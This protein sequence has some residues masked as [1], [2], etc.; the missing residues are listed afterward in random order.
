[1]RAVHL[2]GAN[3]RST[4]PP[5]AKRA[6][7]SND[8]YEIFKSWSPMRIKLICMVIKLIWGDQTRTKMND[9]TWGL[10]LFHAEHQSW[11]ETDSCSVLSWCPPLRDLAT[12]YHCLNLKL[13]ETSHM[14]SEVMKVVMSSSPRPYKRRAWI[15][16]TYPVYST[17]DFNYQLIMKLAIITTSSFQDSFHSRKMSCSR[18]HVQRRRSISGGKH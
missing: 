17:D 18:R 9:R 2:D 5:L 16:C 7:W 15:G 4:R 10:H 3:K 11:L 14:L 1:M 6:L 13:W 12:S 8:D